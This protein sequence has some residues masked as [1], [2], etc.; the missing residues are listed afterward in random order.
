M[1]NQVVTI[2]DASTF[3][4]ADAFAGPFGRWYRWLLPK[5]ARRAAGVIT[6]SNFSRDRLAVT[7]GIAPAKI[8]VVYNG[9]TAPPAAPTADMLRTTRQRLDLPNRFL[10][11]VGSH[12][13]R[14]NVSRLLA[15]FAKLNAPELHLVLAGGSN[16][17]LFNTEGTQIPLPRVRALGHVSEA[18]LESLYALAEGFVFPSLYEGFGLPPLEAMARGCPVLCSNATCLPEVCGPSLEDGGACLY[19]TPHDSGSILSALQKF[20]SL[21]R[22]A[23]GRMAEAGRRHAERYSWECCA[24]E[25]FRA[26]HRFCAAKPHANLRSQIPSE[27]APKLLEGTEANPG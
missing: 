27:A 19:F 3:D 6:V 25:T 16:A 1:R 18:D 23:K 15:E 12:D 7:L 22:E 11:F 26:L 5:L 8:A 20:V 4:C 2:H 17:Q 24:R 13:P 9:V 14:K 21:P 10:L